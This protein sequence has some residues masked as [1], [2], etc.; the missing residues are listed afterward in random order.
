MITLLLAVVLTGGWVRSLSNGDSF[1]F[2][3]GGT[4]T[5]DFV[6]V[7]SSLLWVKRYQPD[8]AE[9]PMTFPEWESHDFI[10]SSRFY[11][12]FAIDA[13][14]WNWQLFGFGSGEHQADAWA[15]GYRCRLW[16]IP[17]WSIIVPFT[18]LSAFLLLSKPC[19]SNPGNTAE[20]IAPKSD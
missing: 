8:S 7:D 14:K 12:I 18:A 2:S 6:S 3:L 9:V 11:H 17:Y 10:P 5:D 13:V 19:P 16:I 4:A 20:P 15:H 1:D